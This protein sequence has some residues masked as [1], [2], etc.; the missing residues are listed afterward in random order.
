[1]PLKEMKFLIEQKFFAV[2]KALVKSGAKA[3]FRA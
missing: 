3:Y 2:R 1:M